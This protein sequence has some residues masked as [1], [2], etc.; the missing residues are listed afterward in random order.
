[1]QIQSRWE[2]KINKVEGK[3]EETQKRLN[4]EEKERELFGLKLE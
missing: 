4:V 2:K 3:K 1:M